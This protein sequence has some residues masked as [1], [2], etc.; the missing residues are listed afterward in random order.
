V[1]INA[2]LS[3]PVNP[4]SPNPVRNAEMVAALSR[5][6]G[7]RPGLPLPALLLRLMLG[8]MAE[9]LILAS[10]RI[11]PGKLLDAGYQFHFAELADAL[12]HELPAG[13]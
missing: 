3:G 5:A 7:R 4:T 12:N 10:R 13:E 1:L 2:A 11:L 6:L 8:E 9:T